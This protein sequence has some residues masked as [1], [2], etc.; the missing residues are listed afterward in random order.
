EC[1]ILGGI[2]RSTVLELASGMGIL[3][4]QR[5]IAA[6]EISV[7][8]ECFLSST[9]VELLPVT[10]I[11][12]RAVGTGEPGPIYKRMHHAYSELVRRG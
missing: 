8:Q 1:D 11:D 3:C 9:G 2:T 7:F 4:E 10:R 5:A 12:G 6:S